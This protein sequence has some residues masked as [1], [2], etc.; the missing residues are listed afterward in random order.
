[1]CACVWVRINGFI[2][3]KRT[4]ARERI[5][6]QIQLF[7]LARGTCPNGTA[8]R[9][10]SG[11]VQRYTSLAPRFFPTRDEIYCRDHG[12]VHVTKGVLGE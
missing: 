4:G 10:F 1:M 8:F 12:A 11:R 3:L 2:P 5:Y 9:S 7:T 6:P